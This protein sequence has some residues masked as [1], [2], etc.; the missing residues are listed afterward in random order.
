MFRLLP[1]EKDER[2]HAR[3][4]RTRLI[5][6]CIKCAYLLDDARLIELAR[7]SGVPPVV[8]MRWIRL[9]R[10]EQDQ[11][12]IRIISRRRGRDSAWVRIGINRRRLSREVDPE[13]RQLLGSRIAKDHG[14]YIRACQVIQ[15]SRT[16]LPNRQV[17]EIL[18][19]SKSTVDSGVARILRK[20]LPLYADEEG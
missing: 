14:V 4:F 13:K 17:A 20:Y 1:D 16:M 8:M 5:Y 7:L 6:L 3:A 10:L 15:N 11:Q 9:A 2:I 12:S 18:G 19:V